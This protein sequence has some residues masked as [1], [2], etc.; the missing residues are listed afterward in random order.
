[1]SKFTFFYFTNAHKTTLSLT[2]WCLNSIFR[3][4]KSE[5]SSFRSPYQTK[6]QIM[7]NK[8]STVYTPSNS[9]LYCVSRCEKN[10][11]IEMCGK[12]C[13]FRVLK[14]TFFVHMFFGLYIFFLDFFFN[15]TLQTQSSNTSNSVIKHNTSK[16]LK[17]IKHIK[18]T[19]FYRN[20]AL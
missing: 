1:V 20:F 19:C 6:L 15:S 9:V 3:T 18:F 8:E 2:L 11:F 5:K 4:E 10:G 14:S 16:P 13:R 17:R 7:W 12:K